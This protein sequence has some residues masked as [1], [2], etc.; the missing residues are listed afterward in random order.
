MLLTCGRK[1]HHEEEEKKGMYSPFFFERIEDRS[2]L[3]A[4]SDRLP[5]RSGPTTPWGCAQ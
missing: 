3:K 1:T 4:M 5:D 2:N